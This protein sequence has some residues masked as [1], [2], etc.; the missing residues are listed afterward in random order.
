MEYF[1]KYISVKSLSITRW[2]TRANACY[3][4]F[5]SYSEIANAFDVIANNLNEK[6]ICRNEAKELIK[7]LNSL[8]MGIMT[9]LWNYILERFD[10]N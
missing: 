7:L 3:A 9:C 8:E 10:A 5:K 2:C 1:S 4:L 6:V